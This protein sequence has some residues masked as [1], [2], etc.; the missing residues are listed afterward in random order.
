MMDA[1]PLR[2]AL[3]SMASRFDSDIDV[4]RAREE[5]DARA[6]RRRRRQRRFSSATVIVG[7]IVVIAVVLTFAGKGP[8]NSSPT[9]TASTDTSVPVNVVYGNVPSRAGAALAYD[10]ARRQVVLFG[11]Y[12]GSKDFADT[13][14]W[15]GDRWGEAQPVVSPPA[16]QGAAMAYDPTTKELVLF[17]GVVPRSH[18]TTLALDDTWTWNGSTW[19][20]RHPAHEPPW[21]SGLAMS[22]DPRSKSVLLLTLPSS[23]PNLDLTPDSV[24]ARGDTAFGTW[25]W[26]GSDWRELPTPSAPLFLKGAA[27]HISPR[28]TPLPDGAGLLFY[29]WSTYRG[30]CPSGIN[31]EGP[32]DPTNTAHSQTW[33]WDGTHWTQQHP[34]AAPGEASLVV[35]PGNRAA[36]MIF[37]ANGTTWKWTGSNWHETAG[38]GSGP[39]LNGPLAADIAGF[40]VYD[41][42]DRN[43]VAYVPRSPNQF[44]LDDTW[45]WDGS[46]TERFHSP[47]PVTTPTPPP[48]TTTT[49]TTA[50]PLGPC[51][52]ADLHLALTRELQ[53]VMQQPAAFFSLT[54]TSATACT[55]EGYPTLGIFDASGSLIPALVQYGSAYQIND[56]GSRRVV[57]QPGASVYFGFGWVN[58]NEADGGSTKGCLSIESVTALVPGTRTN[59]RTAA[60][61]KSVFCPT[62]EAVTAIAPR[63]A[64]AG[65]TSP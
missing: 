28:L 57:V 18:Q 52:S 29:S 33:T 21:S 26:S 45:T 44:I 65:N 40:A 5:V 23:H 30:S 11:G 50:P 7:A 49:T 64:F 37:A 8:N 14:L 55:I 41:T 62:S 42:A 38:R 63:A 56:P 61:L 16:R 13:W 19:T 32:P 12:D 1:D 43:V 47:R 3:G 35:T 60:H 31:C 51:T 17:G 24:N 15:D 20:Q 22:Y 27:L 10:A 9:I 25:Q 36:P 48:P 54:N 58:V 46:W 53:S 6:A 2:D 34:I 4:E 59:L 39:T